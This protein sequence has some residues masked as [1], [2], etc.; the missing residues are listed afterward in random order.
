MI[1]GLL[2]LHTAVAALL[3]SGCQAGTDMREEAETTELQVTEDDLWSRCQYVLASL[4]PAA[5]T[6]RSSPVIMAHLAFVELA[7]T[8][9]LELQQHAEDEDVDEQLAFLDLMLVA[10]THQA[11]RAYAEEALNEQVCH[12][13]NEGSALAARW[14]TDWGAY[15]DTGIPDTDARWRALRDAAARERMFFDLHLTEH[16]GL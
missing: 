16:C 15:P 10:S 4:E 13:L 14:Y 1:R 11:V 5:R 7:D 2:I 6:G 3:Q 9:R 8:C 12:W